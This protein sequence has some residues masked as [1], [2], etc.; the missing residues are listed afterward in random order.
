MYAVSSTFGG[1]IRILGNVEVELLSTWALRTKEGSHEG[2]MARGVKAII[3]PEW[4]VGAQ[5]TILAACRSM[6]LSMWSM[7]GLPSGPTAGDG[8]PVVF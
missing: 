4:K 5:M 3:L 8:P 7:R 6:W 2:V 1:A